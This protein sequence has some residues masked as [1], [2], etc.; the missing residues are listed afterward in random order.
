MPRHG[1]A[2]FTTLDILVH[3]WDLAMATGQPVDLDGRPGAHMLG[4]AEQS[5]ATPESRARRIGL[6][7]PVAVDAP[8]AQRR[9]ITSQAIMPGGE[10]SGSRASRRVLFA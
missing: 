10:P 9:S 8:V 1:L 3:G 6:V 7:M 5:L 4:F 2:G